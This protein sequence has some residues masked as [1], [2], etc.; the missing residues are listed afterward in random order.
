MSHADH[1]S[2]TP[3]PLTG[4]TAAASAAP[5]FKP[6][7][8]P[9]PARRRPRLALLAAA[10]VVLGGGAYAY[11]HFIGERYVS[12]DNAYTA[13]EVAQITPAIDAITQR[14]RVVDTR[15]FAR[16]TS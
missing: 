4:D 1:H 14:V 2:D 10:V 15:R 9:Q 6:A 11:H 16:A 8:P 13:A 7:A 12:T 5:T 3:T